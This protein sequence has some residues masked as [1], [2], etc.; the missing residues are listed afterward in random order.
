MVP[1]HVDIPTTTTYRLIPLCF[2]D[3]SIDGFKVFTS[4]LPP[5]TFL[6]NREIT[7]SQT[8]DR[9]HWSRPSPESYAQGE[10]VY[11]LK[12]HVYDIVASNYSQER[13]EDVPFRFQEDI[14]PSGT[15]IHLLGRLADGTSVCVNVFGQSLY[16]YASVPDGL[17]INSA[18]QEVMSHGKGRKGPSFST[19][20]VEKT[21]LTVYTENMSKFTKITLSS[22]YM[23]YQ[24]CDKL[25]SMNVALYETNVD[26]IQRFIIDHNF[27]TFGWYTCSKGTLR[28]HNRDSMCQV[29]IDC[30]LDDL[31]LHPEETSW[32]PYNILSFDIECIGQLGFPNA[33]KESDTIIQIS[34]IVWNCCS[35]IPEKILISL[36]TCNK[37]DD[38]LIYECPS[39]YDL[40]MCFLTLLRDYNIEFITGYNISNFD[41]PYI[42]DRATHIYNIDCTKFTKM[43][44]DSIFEVRKPMDSGAGFMRSQ[45]KIKI[46][47][48]VPVDMYTVCKDKLSLSDYKLNTVAKHCLGQEKNDVSYK[49]IPILFKSGPVGRAKVG[50]YCIMDS[51]LVLDLLQYF[52][53]H[54]EITEIGK[55]AKIP[56]RRVLTD[57]Q[58][59]RVFSCLLDAARHE[60]YILPSTFTRENCEGYQGA[61]VIDPISGFYSTPVLVVDFASLYPSIIQAHNLCYSTIIPATSLC[62]YPNLTC[63][64][65]ETF[66]LPSGPVHFV[67]KH[68]KC[69]I[70]SKL[71]TKWLTK[72]KQLK[73]Q[74]AKC[75]DDTTKTIIDKQQ[76]AIKVTCNSVYGFTGVASGMLPCLKIAETVTFRGRQMLE[77]S[78][79]YIE[80]ITP[81]ILG[82]MTGRSYQNDCRFKVIYGDTDSLFVETIGYTLNQVEEFCDI[83]AQNTTSAL[84]VD[85]IKLEA[86]KIFKSLLMI[87]KKRYVGLLSNDK[88]LLKGV[89]L[90][91]KTACKYVQRATSQIVNLILNDT[92]VKSAAQML[93]NWNKSDV[94]AKGLPSGFSKVI[95]ALN[96]NYEQLA[97]CAVEISDLTFTTELSRPLS[98]YK[99]TNLPHLTVYKKLLERQEELPQLHDRIPYVFISGTSKSLKSD[100]AE[101]PSFVAQN[102]LKIA[103]NLYFDKLLHSV[104]NI[105]QCLFKNDPDFTV[106]VLYN[107]LH[108]RPDALVSTVNDLLIQLSSTI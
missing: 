52:M 98:E 96:H 48:I 97:T 5:V 59:I 47:G 3:P 61:T 38:T 14:I 37:I 43:K 78:R 105:I 65:Y 25:K 6:N 46:T 33:L 91:R 101:H 39:E 12:F 60:H 76:L 31:Q 49:E 72:R 103:T 26:A 108:I 15:V 17:L 51:I 44:I 86:E 100:L 57:G 24:I 54:I 18:L 73:Q 107:F 77:L 53:A 71:L 99:T 83:L 106:K 67:K 88:L 94:Y 4:T 45:T 84:F 50:S 22:S 58:Q 104:A 40:I 89:D 41:L 102:N 63:S 74:L 70:L 8:S 36:G 75:T 10:H 82:D 1:V 62:Q 93:T 87:T 34:C 11:D 21:P 9:S 95:Q 80:N 42:I 16:F 81:E 19:C 28:L 27:S 79:S 13:C 23:F 90:V 92:D 32:P 68:K 85:P 7:M 2:R 20:E 64:D 35:K 56:I 55:L 66:N 69:S 29:E 30:G